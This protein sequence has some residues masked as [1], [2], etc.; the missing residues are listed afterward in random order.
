[1]RTA[2]DDP[3]NL[4]LGFNLGILDNDRSHNGEILMDKVLRDAVSSA[5]ASGHLFDHTNNKNNNELPNKLS[6]SFDSLYGSNRGESFHSD[7]HIRKLYSNGFYFNR[8]ALKNDLS[9]AD[10]ISY[11]RKRS[12]DHNNNMNKKKRKANRNIIHDENL[13]HDELL[14]ESSSISHG[15]VN[16]QASDAIYD[17]SV[18]YY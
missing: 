5:T 7:Q 3:F 11:E 12:N 2:P 10:S 15:R 18:S 6:I 8:D 4:G 1:M 14:Q 9:S 17:D 16:N 13:L